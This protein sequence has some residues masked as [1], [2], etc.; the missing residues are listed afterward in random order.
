VQLLARALFELRAPPQLKQGMDDEPEA[1]QL[2]NDVA[3]R[4][5]KTLAPLLIKEAEQND[6]LVTT[7]P[8]ADQDSWRRMEKHLHQLRNACSELVTCFKQ[9]VYILNVMLAEVVRLKS[10]ATER[11][12]DS[13]FAPL[14]PRLFSKVEG[15][16]WMGVEPTLNIV[17]NMVD[18]VGRSLAEVCKE[19][20]HVRKIL[21]QLELQLARLTCKL[22]CSK[23]HAHLF[24][25]ALL[26]F[27][28]T[29][30]YLRPELK[31][32]DKFEVL[33]VMFE[34]LLRRN[35]H[36]HRSNAFF[37]I[38]LKELHE[39]RRQLQESK[40]RVAVPAGTAAVNLR[41][42]VQSSDASMPD[43]DAAPAGE[44]LSAQ[45]DAPAAVVSGGQPPADANE[46]GSSAKEPMAAEAVEGE[47]E[48]ED[49]SD[50]DDSEMEKLMQ[51]LA[52]CYYAMHD[53][54]VR[55]YRSE[56]DWVDNLIASEEG[57]E[58][59]A[60]RGSKVREGGAGEGKLSEPL[61]L[62]LW[63]FVQPLAQREGGKFVGGA[64]LNELKDL[65]K[66]ILDVLKPDNK[67]FVYKDDI[68]KY[69]AF[70][71]NT[72]PS[73]SDLL[74]DFSAV[75]A[76]MKSKVTPAFAGLPDVSEGPKAKR[77][78]DKMECLQNIFFLLAECFPL[79]NEEQ[80]RQKIDF[81]LLDLHINPWR[82]ES[83]IGLADSYDELLQNSSFGIRHET[84]VEHSRDAQQAL[85]NCLQAYSA[86]LAVAQ[87]D[88][89]ATQ[90]ARKRL[91]VALYLL[92]QGTRSSK[93]PYEPRWFA[94]TCTR[95]YELFSQACDDQDWTVEYYLGKV[96][97]CG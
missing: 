26:L 88:A 73:M 90:D 43:A 93:S 6:W 84:L 38:Y 1:R 92:I 83:W 81:Y 19:D 45:L 56:Y 97:A 3:E 77:A 68:T 70:F 22:G 25:K 74:P 64:S 4:T 71:G 13:L 31:F 61:A 50:D 7:L 57:T 33:H 79:G 60:R 85:C 36:G 14:H 10:V 48:G 65:L 32:E 59:E 28:K 9:E 17:A 91:G 86:V 52:K 24:H 30:S 54:K 8:S 39:R 55:K 67:L 15:A 72:L 20:E 16:V 11:R 41:Q 95:A 80:N 27:W 49:D 46:A 76:R 51:E 47:R 21:H 18:R 78:K 40:A 96:C 29:Y 94:T 53:F 12:D 44:A 35:V 37:K 89:D 82:K 58:G 75:L 34:E 2:V 42:H 62:D 63:S 87:G 23:E 66:A 5:V 69:L